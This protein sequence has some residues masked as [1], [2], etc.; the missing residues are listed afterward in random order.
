MKQWEL[1]TLIIKAQA[2]I[3]KEIAEPLRGP[4]REKNYRLMCDT[5]MST[6]SKLSE[7]LLKDTNHLQAL[8]E[9]DI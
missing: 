4:I 3:L 6:L 7:K 2:D 8:K 1:E 9:N 5:L